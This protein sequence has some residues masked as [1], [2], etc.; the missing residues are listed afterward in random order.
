MNKDQGGIKKIA[1]KSPFQSHSPTFI[2]GPTFQ[3]STSPK[4]YFLGGE[5]LENKACLSI[6][7]NYSNRSSSSHYHHSGLSG[8]RS[9]DNIG[10][11]PICP[12]SNKSTT[13]VSNY[14]IRDKIIE[15]KRSYRENKAQE[16]RENNSYL[17]TRSNKK[18][19]QSKLN[20]K[21]RIKEFKSKLNSLIHGNT[22]SVKIENDENVFQNPKTLHK[23]NNSMASK[24]LPHI[25]PK[26][27]SPKPPAP[28]ALSSERRKLPARY[29]RIKTPD[30][31]L[32]REPETNRSY[33]Q[34]DLKLIQA[35]S[36]EGLLKNL[37]AE[38]LSRLQKKEIKKNSILKNVYEE[39]SWDWSSP[40][41][42]PAKLKRVQFI[43]SDA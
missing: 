29:L 39:E 9:S 20:L 26:N 1:C 11:L 10:K 12:A 2:N 8:I 17:S 5:L 25:E 40:D 21:I 42:S 24:C 30:A 19:K 27:L 23:S 28:R 14:K 36:S 18:L 32:S 43:N 7:N 34:M 6:L 38:K 31:S 37:E 35:T 3:K 41:G 33:I 22:P 15:T 4:R 16:S 13:P